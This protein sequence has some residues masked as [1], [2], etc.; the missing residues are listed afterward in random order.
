MSAPVPSESLA[1]TVWGL[2]TFE[3]FVSPTLLIWFYYLGAVG[4][5]I[6][7]L[8][9]MRQLIAVARRVDIP[10]SDATEELRK[11]WLKTAMGI[12]LMALLSLLFFELFWR[13]LFEFLL[14]YFQMRDALV[15]PG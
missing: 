13:M 8:L 9:V 3:T 15:G 2:V 7:G 1:A 10:R 5:P 6:V 14:A 12:R 11:A 4:G